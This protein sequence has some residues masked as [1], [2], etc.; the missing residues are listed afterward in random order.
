MGGSTFPV[1]MAIP[2]DLCPSHCVEFPSLVVKGFRRAVSTW[3]VS[4]PSTVALELP[5]VATWLLQGLVSG[6]VSFHRESGM[7]CSI[8]PS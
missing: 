2:A 8:F 3:I 5:V 6:A 7:A 4:L 1:C